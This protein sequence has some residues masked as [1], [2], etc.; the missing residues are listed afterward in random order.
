MSLPVSVPI[1][2]LLISLLVVFV[3]VYAFM[4][5]RAKKESRATAFDANVLLNFLEERYGN[6]VTETGVD[7]TTGE[8]FTYTH[9]VFPPDVAAKVEAFHVKHPG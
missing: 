6:P 4:S 8:A 5:V 9:N 1:Q 3:A 2:V 7:D